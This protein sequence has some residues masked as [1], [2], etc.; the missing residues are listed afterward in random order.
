MPKTTDKSAASSTETEV[1]Q[2]VHVAGG[3]ID[4]KQ[5]SGFYEAYSDFA[6]NVR[7]WFIAYGIGGPVLF[8]SSDS[9]W[10]SLRDS[11]LGPGVVY[12]FLFGVALQIIGALIYKSAMWYLY[13]GELQP[14][15]QK[16]RRYKVAD[17]LSENYLIE[18]G[19]DV[20]TLVLFG[21]ATL[22]TLK[23]LVA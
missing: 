3:D 5:E 2:T 8:A 4:V 1:D 14:A 10:P 11:G 18:A 12:L 7:T 13:V 15:F 21:L 9:V 6:R 19:I 23:V 20:V 22:V 16:T 17:W